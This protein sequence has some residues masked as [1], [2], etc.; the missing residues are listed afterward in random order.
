[1]SRPVIKLPPDWQALA[2]KAVEAGWE[3][4]HTG[5]GHIRWLPPI[6]RPLFSPSTPGDR[7]GLLNFRS[8]LRRTGLKV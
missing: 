3:L 1:M 7:R 8:M 5:S 4:S 6:G 2:D